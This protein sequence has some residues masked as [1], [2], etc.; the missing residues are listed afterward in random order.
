MTLKHHTHAEQSRG[1]ARSL[2]AEGQTFL[3]KSG[4]LT[5]SCSFFV[6]FPGGSQGNK[7]FPDRTDFKKQANYCCKYLSEKTPSRPN[8]NTRRVVSKS[9]ALPHEAQILFLMIS[10]SMADA[11]LQH[12]K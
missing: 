1:K 2:L 11:L 5:D 8:M 12:Q 10:R 9:Y 6:L 3:L 4:K 7:H